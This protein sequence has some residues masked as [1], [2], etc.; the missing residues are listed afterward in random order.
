[1]KNLIV[2]FFTLAMFTV[3]GQI[4][5][6]SV[7]SVY[8]NLIVAIG[9]GSKI[10]PPIEPSR[11]E[12]RV[13][14]YSPSRQTV[15]VEEKFLTVCATFGPDSLNALAFILG[16]ELA[17]FYRN[18]GWAS[19]SGMGYIDAEM[20]A[21]WKSMKSES[22]NRAKDESEADIFSGFYSLIAGYDAMPVAEKTLKALYKSYG[23]PDS[24]PG[25]PTL[26]QRVGIADN[27]MA[28]SRSLYV[29]FNVGIYCLATEKFNIASKIFTSIYNDDYAG[30]E[31]LNNLAISEILQGYQILG[32]SP[33]YYY[34]VF[35]STETP[36]DPDSRGGEGEEHIRTGIMYLKEALKKEDNNVLLFTNL[37][38]A[39]AMLNEFVDAEYYVSK[40]EAIDASNQAA[41]CLRG[42]IASK[43]GDKKLA[44]SIWKKHMKEN[45]LISK[46]YAAQ[47]EKTPEPVFAE[48]KAD[49][50]VLQIVDE[51]DLSSRDFKSNFSFEVVKLPGLK[52]SYVELENSM[53]IEV[54]GGSGIDYRFQSF[55]SSD[56]ETS[57]FSWQKVLR[58]NS[59]TIE[60]SQNYNVLKMSKTDA[61]IPVYVK[62]VW[63]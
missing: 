8:K 40:I 10:A 31:I 26:A 6:T 28:K 29:Q 56:F 62:Y 3:H 25:Y 20:K 63:Y 44:K 17:H 58:S 54:Y 34:P 59:S 50:S 33:T 41:Y 9:D 23:I 13:A 51:V 1:M 30:G 36:L 19:A 11:T 43:K 47:F 32:E 22:A 42:I 39:Y 7:E 24:I 48:A 12:S 4:K 21:D 61:E 18:H 15:Y 46:N 57:N 55:K 5:W 52:I 2:L 37:A 60:N 35:I 16:H 53:I 14:Y 38:S 45:A 49:A 27:A